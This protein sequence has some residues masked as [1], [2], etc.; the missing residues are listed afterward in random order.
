MRAMVDRAM[1]GACVVVVALGLVLVVVLVL[2]RA[3]VQGA[4]GRLG[5]G[6]TMVHPG[7]HQWQD[8]NT[9]CRLRIAAAPAEHLLCCWSSGPESCEMVALVCSREN[10]LVCWRIRMKNHMHARH[11]TGSRLEQEH[12]DKRVS[13]DTAA[14]SAGDDGVVASL[15][16]Q[17]EADEGLAQDPHDLELAVLCRLAQGINGHKRCCW[18]TCCHCQQLR[19]RRPIMRQP[20]IKLKPCISSK[21][22]DEE[23][24]VVK[25]SVAGFCGRILCG[26]SLAQKT[27]KV[28]ELNNKKFLLHEAVREETPS[29][30]FVRKVDICRIRTVI[31][32]RARHNLGRWLH[33]VGGV[34]LMH[35][36]QRVH[37]STLHGDF[38]LC[39]KRI[40]RLVHFHV[41]LH[42][43]DSHGIILIGRI[44]VKSLRSFRSRDCIVSR[45]EFCQRVRSSAR[46]LLA[47]KVLK[48][49]SLDLW[50][51]RQNSLCEVSVLRR[52]VRIHRRLILNSAKQAC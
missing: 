44:L 52:I 49:F 1:F 31:E 47:E 30:A 41:V 17:L 24:F 10:S 9:D 20:P 34:K 50:W 13:K 43:G 3:G 46:V 42:D 36:I 37:A 19:A 23:G 25:R 35:E 21:A 27:E 15:F 8:R 29:S 6:P 32:K 48:H 12:D 7:P 5:G 11:C 18:R 51:G 16:S 45:Q 40:N 4:A 22:G 26:V 14:P 2:D 39:Q 28:W 33:S 38:L